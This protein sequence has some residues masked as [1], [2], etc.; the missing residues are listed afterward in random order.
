MW[1]YN[2][3]KQQQHYFNVTC[4][5]YTVGF[6]IIIVIIALI[7][8]SFVN[9]TIHL[10]HEVDIWT[11]W[12]K[13]SKSG[14]SGAKSL[15]S[16]DEDHRSNTNQTAMIIIIIIMLNKKMTTTLRCFSQSYLGISQLFIHWTKIQQQWTSSK[17]IAIDTLLPIWYYDINGC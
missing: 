17:V 7:T 13:V 9:E 1:Q 16:T 3:C 2:A 8:F 4:S 10:Y 14:L 15:I 11:Q 5:K 12:C 6:W